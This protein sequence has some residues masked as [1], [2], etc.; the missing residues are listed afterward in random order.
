MVE[1]LRGSGWIPA[2]RVQ[3]AGGFPEKLL[4]MSALDQRVALRKYRIGSGRFVIG[5]TA[6]DS[7]SDREAARWERMKREN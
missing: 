1:L 5:D 6:L 7:P 4:T 3:G 2:L